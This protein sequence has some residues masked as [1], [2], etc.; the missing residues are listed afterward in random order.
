M[1]RRDQRVVS[2]PKPT[3]TPTTPTPPKPKSAAVRQREYRARVAEG[4]RCVKLYPSVSEVDALIVEAVRSLDPKVEANALLLAEIKRIE[5]S[6]F[7]TPEEEHALGVHV[8]ERLLLTK[9]GK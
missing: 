4:R 7:T 1:T 2:L 3:S 9:I 5:K 6:D 8:I